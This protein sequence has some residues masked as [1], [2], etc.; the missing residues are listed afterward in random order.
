VLVILILTKRQAHRGRAKTAKSGAKRAKTALTTFKKRT[1]IRD[2]TVANYELWDEN[3]DGPIPTAYQEGDHE[4]WNW[5]TQYW[6]NCVRN[7]ESAEFTED[8]LRELCDYYFT[9]DYTI[10][11]G[12][13][14][15]AY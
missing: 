9:D 13:F 1:L 8:E 4:P 7:H 2:N 5:Y 10:Y 12:D 14:L 3:S 15:D 6:S 11:T